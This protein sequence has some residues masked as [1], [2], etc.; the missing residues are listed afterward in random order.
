[1]LRGSPSA[2]AVTIPTRS[3]VNGPGPAPHTTASSSRMPAPA[4]V[5]TSRTDGMSSSPWAQP[6]PARQ[7]ILRITHFGLAGNRQAR[8]PGYQPGRAAQLRDPAV[9]AADVTI[10]PPQP[11]Q[12][13]LVGQPLGHA[14]PPLHHHGCREQIG[15]QVEVVQFGDP[16]E[17][18]GI[19]V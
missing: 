10:V 14:L 12:Q 3:P 1:M 6:T 8:R 13:V 2:A 11:D 15:I 7:A 17:P 19:D 16:A 18:V 4:L 9:V 5:I